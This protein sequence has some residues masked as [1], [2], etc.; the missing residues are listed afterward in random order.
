MLQVSR[1]GPS[2]IPRVLHFSVRPL[3]SLRMALNMSYDKV[4]IE[5]SMCLRAAD[6]VSGGVHGVLSKLSDECAGRTSLYGQMM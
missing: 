6:S 4:M 1:F 3:C 2:L 5:L